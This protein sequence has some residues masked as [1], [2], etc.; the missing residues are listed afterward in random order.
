MWVL[1]CKYGGIPKKGQIVRVGHVPKISA[2]IDGIEQVALANVGFENYM[3]V[4]KNCT[5]QTMYESSAKFAQMD[6]KQKS[7]STDSEEESP[8]LKKEA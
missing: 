4:L 8:K 6:K 5:E 2:M 1:E 3:N 7:I